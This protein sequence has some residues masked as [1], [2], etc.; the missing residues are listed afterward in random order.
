MPEVRRMT[1]WFSPTCKKRLMSSLNAQNAFSW[2]AAGMPFTMI[3]ALKSSISMLRRT[4]SSFSISSVT[5]KSRTSH[6]ERSLIHWFFFVF[7]FK[8]GSST[9]P[10]SMRA[11]VTSPGTVMGIKPYLE[12]NAWFDLSVITWKCGFGSFKNSACSSSE[13]SSSFKNAGSVARTGAAS[14]LRSTSL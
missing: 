9:M 10:F 11:V 7:S 5:S 14:I 8:K 2:C 6:Q 4:M 3:S 13:R 12:G 1:S